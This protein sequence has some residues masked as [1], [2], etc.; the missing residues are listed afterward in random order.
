MIRGILLTKA[1]LI[2]DGRTDHNST[3]A[4]PTSSLNLYFFY[5]VIYCPFY[6]TSRGDVNE[7]L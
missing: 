5:L 1:Y 6:I 7:E 4:H 3:L 2:K